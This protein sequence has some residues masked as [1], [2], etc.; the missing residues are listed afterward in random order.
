[1]KAIKYTF[2][3]SFFI[4]LFAVLFSCHETTQLEECDPEKGRFING[5]HY[6]LDEFLNEDKKLDYDEWYNKFRS[7][8]KFIP[9][10]IPLESQESL[11]EILDE[12]EK[13]ADVNR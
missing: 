13:T 10:C 3:H 6:I 1:M 9:V 7:R 5:R 12:E 2:L 11:E 8:Y 4:F